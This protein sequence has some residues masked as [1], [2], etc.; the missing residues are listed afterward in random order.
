MS[1]SK[2]G[3]KNVNEAGRTIEDLLVRNNIELHYTNGDTLTHLYCSGT[4]TN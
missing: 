4:T 1:V 2:T 3:Y